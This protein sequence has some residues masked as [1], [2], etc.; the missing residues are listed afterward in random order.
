MLKIYVVAIGKDWTRQLYTGHVHALPEHSDAVFECSLNDPTGKPAW[1]RVV[2]IS[3]VGD[4]RL[5]TTAARAIGAAIQDAE[6]QAIDIEAL[7]FLK[8]TCRAGSTEVFSGSVHGEQGRIVGRSGAWR[9]LEGMPLSVWALAMRVLCEAAFG[10]PELDSPE[11][12]LPPTVYRDQGS[13][14]CLSRDLPYELCTAFDLA[15]CFKPKPLVNGQPDACHLSDVDEFLCL[16]VAGYR[17]SIRRLRFLDQA[18]GE[19]HQTRKI[20]PAIGKA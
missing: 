14:Y 2:A 8:V 13:S 7:R 12:T 3:G 18:Q 10:R 6:L 5:Y 16:A 1:E 20:E 19:Q 17:D 4:E 9:E 11:V 15:Y